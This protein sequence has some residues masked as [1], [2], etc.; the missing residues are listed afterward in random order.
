M[1]GFFIPPYHPC[2]SFHF[3]F[4][5]VVILICIFLMSNEVDSFS[6]FNS[7]PGNLFVKYSFKSL[8]HFLYRIV[9]LLID[10]TSLYVLEISPLSVTGVGNTFSMCVAYIFPL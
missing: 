5:F 2:L 8:T 9:C 7:H 4:C 3:S 1:G 10:G 6:M